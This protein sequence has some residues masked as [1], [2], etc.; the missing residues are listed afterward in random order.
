MSEPRTKLRMALEAAKT[1]LEGRHLVADE[2]MSNE[3][4]PSPAPASKLNTLLGTA[5]VPPQRVSLFQRVGVTQRP[6]Y[7]LLAERV[8]GAD[9]AAYQ[10][11]HSGYAE[12]V[13]ARL[14]TLRGRWTMEA[15]ESEEELT[16]MVG[17]EVDGRPV[18]RKVLD[19]RR[20]EASSI[21]TGINDDIVVF[22]EPLKAM[23]LKRSAA[24]P[25]PLSRSNHR[26]FKQWYVGEENF[27]ATQACEGVVD[28]P[29]GS[30][31]PVLIQAE[32]HSG[33]SHLLHATGQALLRRQT[34]RVLRLSASD[35]VQRGTMEPM[36]EHAMADALALLVDDLHE[37]ATDDVWA[38]H[39][40][41]MVDHALNLGV[42]VV[43]GGRASMDSMPP[44]RLKDVLRSSTIVHL[45]QPGFPTLLAYARWRS[46]ST[47]LLLHD[48]HL[49][50]LVA[51]D[52]A[53][54]GTVDARL[55]QVALALNKGEVLMEDDDVLTLIER[56]TLG[57]ADSTPGH[58]VE[59]ASVVA[60][61]LVKDAVDHVFSDVDPGGIE[62]LSSS[63][64]M[65]DDDYAP[66]DWSADDF[67]GKE[68][69]EVEERVRRT[70]ERITPSMP[71]VLDVNERDR[72]LLQRDSHLRMDDVDRAV[73]M[74]VDLELSIDATLGGS[75]VHTV[76]ANSELHALENAMVELAQRAAQADIEELITIADELRTIEERLVVLDPDRAP[77]PVFEEEVE[78]DSTAKSPQKKQRF[79]RRKK[80][81]QPPSPSELDEYTPDG[82]WNIQADDIEA[83]ALLEP[84]EPELNV[85]R[86]ARIRPVERLMGEEE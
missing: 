41:V 9:V 37:F 70:M 64:E 7:D 75:D 59:P 85:V 63:V 68:H 36:W 27:S 33:C 66:P 35:V 17:W 49:S 69:A 53:T 78:A 54:W 77:L 20:G 81:S 14:R 16:S 48:V 34:G 46:S 55:E 76:E 51:H 15:E 31:N 72:Y 38:H 1:K 58:G 86:L 2:P 13:A 73:D 83:D 39:L 44:S 84:G 43:L 12:H 56:G 67:V 22:D 40:G 62:L 8:L 47:N 11:K 3:A 19:D 79:G 26:T 45:R 71:S 32:P 4:S 21:S 65:G 57:R 5:H 28:R 42:Q 18:W 61:R 74:L 80:P 25:S 30:L 82:E 24:W 50:R 23:T 60:Q 29:A 10:P 52:G 6:T